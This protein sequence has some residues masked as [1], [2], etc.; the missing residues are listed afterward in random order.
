MGVLNCSQLLQIMG[1]LN[2]SQLIAHVQ[3]RARH[4]FAL[5]GETLGVVSNT[6]FYRK[7]LEVF[8]DR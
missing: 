5:T 1:V 6:E 7:A 3:S 2:C 8:P 4:A